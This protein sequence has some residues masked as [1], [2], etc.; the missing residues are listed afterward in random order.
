MT[1]DDG[2]TFELA[3]LF[4]WDDGKAAAAACLEVY[5]DEFGVSL[6]QVCVPGVFTDFEAVKTGVAFVWGA[7]DVAIL[8][9]A[10]K[11]RHSEFMQLI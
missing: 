2:E 10:Y 1:I 6:D 8:A 7:I 11:S 3:R 5:T 9:G 4:M